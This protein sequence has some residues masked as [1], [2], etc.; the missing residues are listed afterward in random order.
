MSPKN[1]FKMTV[2]K[3]KKGNC[4]GMFDCSIWMNGLVIQY[5]TGTAFET[6]DAARAYGKWLLGNYKSTKS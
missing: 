3:I 5:A 4:R 1:K 6:R 2:Y